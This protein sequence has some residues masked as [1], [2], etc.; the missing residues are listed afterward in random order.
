MANIKHFT[1]FLPADISIDC[2]KLDVQCFLDK[3]GHNT[4]CFTCVS[5]NT[6]SLVNKF[7]DVKDFLSDLNS[8]KL[9]ISLIA[10]QEIWSIPNNLSISIDNYSA[11]HFTSRD[12]LGTNVN[13]GEGIGLLYITIF[14]LSQLRIFLSLS[15][16]SLSLSSSKYIYQNII[17]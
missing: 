9:D 4:D 1:E 10:F 3:N 6:R 11:L 2:K 8:K 12:S 7:P 16:N 15:L 17:T 13:C 14:D 5:L